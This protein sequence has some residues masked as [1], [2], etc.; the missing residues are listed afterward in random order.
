MIRQ[1]R[2]GGP[3][4]LIAAGL[5]LLLACAGARAETRTDA[6][7]LFGE[8]ALPVGFKNFPYVNPDAPKGGDVTLGALGSYDSFNQFILRGTAATDLGRLYDTLLR[9]S[10]DEASVGY[11]HLAQSVVIAPDHRSLTFELRPEARFHDGTPVTAEDVKWT[12]DT[13]RDKGRPNFRQYYEDV[14]T[15]SVDGPL[16]ITFHFKTDKNRDDP[17]IIGALPV[18]PE[19]WWAGKDFTQP[20]TEPPLGSGP[21]VVDHFDLGRNFI[22]RRADDYWAKDLPTAKGLNNFDHIRTEYYRD[23]TVLM[24]AFKSGQIDFRLENIAK[25]WATAY[26]FP[27]VQKGLIKKVSFRHHLPTGMQGYFMNTRRGVFA[28]VRV[29]QAVADVFDFQWLNKNLFYDQY[30]R[31]ESYFSNSDVASRGLPEGDELALLNQYRENLPPELF[32]QPYKLP[33]TDGSGNN[34]EGLRAALTLL[35]QAGWKVRDRKMMNKDGQ[36]LSFEILSNDPTFERVG[37]PYTQWLARLGIAAHVRT[38]DPAQYQRLTDVFDFDMTMLVL[39]QREYPGNEQTDYWTCQAGKLDGSDNESGV[40]DPVV[41]ALVDKVVQAPDKRTLITA[42]RALDRVLLWGWYC[43]PNWHTQTFNAAFWDR[44]GYSKVP[45]RS[46]LV[47]D[48][49]WIDPTVAAATDA[50]R[51]SGP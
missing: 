41:D 12:F 9:S 28:D 23:S 42:T 36:Q 14:D 22:L 16:K 27:A 17:F 6:I 21:Y 48:S 1:T 8:P 11:A 44:F 31:T 47:F 26:D 33:V 20:L 46:G 24:E 45:V 32:T 25:N 2:E 19:H 29:R 50:A 4:R 43:V 34:R 3:M 38:V 30:V 5:M 13:L 49:W 51:L 39:P 37:E 15:L 40:C 7:A 18:L 35:E 10:D